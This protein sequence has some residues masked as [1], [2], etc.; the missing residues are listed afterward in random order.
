MLQFHMGNCAED[1][2]VKYEV[3]RAEQ[4]EFAVQSY[5]LSAQAWEGGVMAREVVPVSVPKKKKQP[6]VMVERDEEY[7][8]CVRT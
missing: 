4:D 1:T 3:S 5:T 8:K 2:A 6:D 7:Q